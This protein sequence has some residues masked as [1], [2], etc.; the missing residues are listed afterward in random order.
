MFVSPDKQNWYKIRSTS[1]KD[2]KINV[3]DYVWISLRRTK[4]EKYYTKLESGKPNLFLEAQVL[5]NQYKE[6]DCFA[7][8]ILDKGDKFIRVGMSP[9]VYGIVRKSD[10]NNPE[11][12]D[13]LDTETIY[14]YKIIN[15]SKDSGR[16][17]AYLIPLNKCDDSYQARNAKKFADN[18]KDVYVNERLLDRLKKEDIDYNAVVQFLKKEVTTSVLKEYI[19]KKIREQIDNHTL[20]IVDGSFETVYI[21]LDIKNIDGVPLAARIVKNERKENTYYATSIGSMPAG[22]DMER[23]VYVDDWVAMLNELAD[24]AAPE[25]WDFPDDTRHNKAIL[26][27]YLKFT[28]YKAR[29][30]NLIEYCGDDAIFNTG[31][32][33][34]KYNDIYCYLKKN[35]NINDV[36]M[37]RWEIGSFATLLSSAGKTLNRTFSKFPDPPAYIKPD[38]LEM[39]YYD[40]SKELFCDFEHIVEDNINRLP[41]EMIRHAVRDEELLSR[42]KDKGDIPEDVRERI[43]RNPEVVRKLENDLQSS[44]DTAKKYCRWNYKTAIPV[45]YARN[46]NIS[47]LLPLSG[48]VREGQIDIALVVER[49]PNGNYQGQT[50]FDLKMAYQDARQ[51]CRPNSEWL[52]PEKIIK[53][54]DKEKNLGKDSQI[55]KLV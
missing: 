14:N 5:I 51:I 45:Y 31:L 20:A 9:G 33:D 21:D 17:S 27:S 24:I 40:S 37:R 3:E 36:F 50:I 47:L 34:V 44:I 23:F 7:A 29:L 41:R 13:N 46:N 10:L 43:I 52:L 32:V 53:H 4:N 8:P 38:C 25:D 42:I 39:I 48:L 6:G 28:F 22:Y 30:D 18:L 49:L 54:E 12:Y 15:L 11:E 19:S 16:F 35:N 2:A 1:I 55:R 26:E